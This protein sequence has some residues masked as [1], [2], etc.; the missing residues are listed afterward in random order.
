MQ[1]TEEYRPKN[2]DGVVGQEIIVTFFR[3]QAKT[4]PVSDWSHCIFTGEPGVG[5]TTMANAIANEFDLPFIEINASKYRKVDDMENVIMNLAKQM[6][7]WGSR[8]IIFLDEADGMTPTSQWILRR[9]MEEYS[10]VSLF[11][12]ACNY[13]S[14]IIDAI[15]DRCLEFTFEPFVPNDLQKI[16]K[17]ICEKEKRELPNQ[18]ELEI[19]IRASGGSARSFTNLLYQKLIGG[20]LPE[21]NF[22]IMEYIRAIKSNDIETANKIAVKTTFR[23]L[24]TDILELLLKYGDKYGDAIRKLGDYL[25]LAPNPPDETLGKA[26]VT[27]QLVKLL[28][29]V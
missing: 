2:L 21:Y 7:E 26:V 1:W 12:F 10:S 3:N 15:F 6:P 4:K 13:K 29:G 17:N 14:K 5:K 25:L 16:A 18:S 23:G 8:K 24:V 19:M 11:I 20:I 9:L 22:N 28:N 27:V